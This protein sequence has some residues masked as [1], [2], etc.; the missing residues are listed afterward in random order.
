MGDSVAQLSYGV[1]LNEED[2]NRVLEIFYES[3]IREKDEESFL[4]LDQP[5]ETEE[6]ILAIRQS[7]TKTFNGTKPIDT[8]FAEINYHDWNTQLK[9][10]LQ[11]H[12]ITPDTPP[13]WL[14]TG[15]RD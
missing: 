8:K 15:Y 10:F 5:Y 13:V 2:F 6:Y 14:L 1:L 7:R 4:V 3:G 12:E 11:Q 9:D